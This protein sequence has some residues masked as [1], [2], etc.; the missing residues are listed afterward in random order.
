MKT[1]KKI[2]LF[3]VILITLLTANFIIWKQLIEDTKQ[4]QLHQIAKQNKQNK[5][6]SLIQIYFFNNQKYISK[7]SDLLN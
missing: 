7:K 1:T 2:I 6:D 4:I 5:Q 3:D